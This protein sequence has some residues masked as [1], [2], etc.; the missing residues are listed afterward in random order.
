MTARTLCACCFLLLVRP[1]AADD[2]APDRLELAAQP[3]VVSVPATAP[4]GRRF[5]ELPALEYRFEVEA[6]CTGSRTPR[7]LSVSVADSRVALAGAALDGGA[8]RELVLTV[9]GRQLA[10]IALDDFC[11]VAPAAGEDMPEGYEAASSLT[12]AS[13]PPR[14]LTVPAVVSAQASL[15]CGDDAGSRISYVT[16]P[17]AVTLAC[18]ADEGSGTDP[19]GRNAAR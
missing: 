15:V 9:P 11:V 4:G 8:V 1:A 17:L 7:S 16:T 6:A 5:V 18:A 14:L 12:A 19:G 2:A 13:A 10:P 3:P